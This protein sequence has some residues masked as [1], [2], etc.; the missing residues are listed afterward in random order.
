[1]AAD[2]AMA[3]PQTLRGVFDY[4]SMTQLLDTYRMDNLLDSYVTNTNC[5]AR[6]VVLALSAKVV[7]K[8]NTK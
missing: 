3:K 4:E 6:S 5:E 8:T 2:A 7:R 1:M